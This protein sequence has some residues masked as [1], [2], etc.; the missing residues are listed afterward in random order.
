LAAVHLDLTPLRRQPQGDD[1]DLDAVVDHLVQVVAGTTSHGHVYRDVRRLRR[2]LGVLVLVDGSGSTGKGRVD[3]ATVT[4]RQLHAAATLVDAF[5]ALGDRV[6]CQ[7]FRSHGRRRVELTTVKGFDGRFDATAR[8]RLAAVRPE[9]FTRLGAAV[10]H[11]ARV[12]VERS[13]S[14][15]WLLVVLSD[16]FPFDAG[17]EGDHAEADSSRALAEA[18]RA[19]VGSLCLSIGAATPD[20]DLQAV[21]GSSTYA[22][23]PHLDELG[24]DL[25][26]LVRA[27]LAGADQSRRLP[28]PA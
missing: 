26:S 21:F 17:Y 22:A 5:E 18:R 14:R 25:G 7:V 12:L 4:E 10:R 24:A 28:R 19:G 13:G 16:G 8:A 1:L 6:A 9:G 27:A 3:G 15:R 23:G 20:V 11:A 2:D